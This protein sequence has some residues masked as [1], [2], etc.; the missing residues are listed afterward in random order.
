MALQDLTPQLRTRLSRMERA[1][2][3]FVLLAFVLLVFGFVYYAYTTATR[4][5]W[6]LTKAPYFTFLDSA[7]GLNVG[8]PVMMMGFQVGQI[9][10]ITAQP[11]DDFYYNVYV[12][13]ELKRPY[14]GYMWTEGSMSRV[15]SELLGRRVLEVTK[16]TNGYPTYIFSPLREIGVADAKSLPALA[17]WELGQEVLSPADGKI[18]APA[19]EHLGLE[20]LDRIAAAGIS[21]IVVMD[22]RREESSMTGTWNDKQGRY[23]PYTNGVSEYWLMADEAPPVTA[24]LEKVVGQ[25][26]N[27]LPGILSLTNQLRSVLT[28]STELLSNLN[29][30]VLSAKP[31]ISNLATAT[32][33]LDQ[34]GALGNRLIPTNV[35]YQLEQTLQG[36]Q[37]TLH[38]ANTN[39][40]Y[41]VEKLGRSLDNLAMVTSNLNTQVEGN[42]NLLTGISQAVTHTDELV[43][44]LKRHWLLRSAFREKKTNAP[45][46]LPAEP[47]RSPKGSQK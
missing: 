36:A 42:T 29:V 27:A 18:I 22:T 47:L 26:E 31:A 7:S 16:G 33:G 6:F 15:V 25:V 24:R 40:A 8:D 9:T 13:F 32:A 44:G 3:W 12:Q 10:R 43:Q 5:G 20:L 17:K 34:P 2:G 35:N 1:V 11:A 46:A 41:L 21:T 45:P 30:A 14:Y 37:E 23:V 38:S 39:L 19:R 28:N 4:K